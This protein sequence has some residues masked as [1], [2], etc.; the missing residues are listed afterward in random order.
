MEKEPVVLQLTKELRDNIV[1]SHCKND[2]PSELDLSKAW[3]IAEIEYIH[4][5]HDKKINRGEGNWLKRFIK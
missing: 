1:Y 2:E 5:E 3:I 4:E